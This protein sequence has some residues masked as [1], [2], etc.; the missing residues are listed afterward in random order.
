MEEFL[1]AKAWNNGNGAPAGYG[2]RLSS[3]SRTFFRDLDS[4]TLELPNGTAV[5][6]ELSPSFQR[7][8]PEFRR[9]EIGLWLLASK[10]AP[11]PKGE[12]PAFNLRRVSP[13]RFKVTPT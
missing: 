11:W 13:S 4:V 6:I 2:L 12:P 10:L 9:A 5:N 8:C 7:N 1:R 3:D